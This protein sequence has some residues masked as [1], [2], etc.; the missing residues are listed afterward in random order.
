MDKK[1]TLLQ[2]QTFGLAVVTILIGEGFN[3]YG[4]VFY[5]FG[6]EYNA[7]ENAIYI[8]LRRTFF[9]F[10]FFVLHILK[11]SSGLGIVISIFFYTHQLPRF[12]T[13]VTY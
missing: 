9:I 2:L 13:V 5:D 8:C 11:I 6:R 12:D 3:V 7:L 4:S 1:N 10:P